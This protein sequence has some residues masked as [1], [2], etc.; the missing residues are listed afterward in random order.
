MSWMGF[1]LIWAGEG[2]AAGNGRGAFQMSPTFSEFDGLLP[3]IDKNDLHGLAEFFYL[4]RN[5]KNR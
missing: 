3:R 5:F 4:Y 1:R 2:V